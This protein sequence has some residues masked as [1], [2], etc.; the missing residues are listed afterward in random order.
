MNKEGCISVNFK[1]I[2]DNYEIVKNKINY[3]TAAVWIKPAYSQQSNKFLTEDSKDELRNWTLQLSD[4]LNFLG[5][6]IPIFIVVETRD[7]DMYGLWHQIAGDQDWHRGDFAVLPCNGEKEAD[8]VFE[9]VVKD[10]ISFEQYILQPISRSTISEYLL[11]E[12]KNLSNSS[13]IQQR[14]H[15]NL[16]E[17]V[18]ACLNS[19]GESES[20]FSSWKAEVEKIIDVKASG[21]KGDE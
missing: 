10:S 5:L 17:E 14:I 2:S 21:G 9:N 19:N 20:A 6:N 8:K 15:A 16:I 3:I 7:N 13:N 11:D 18:A 4:V 1:K 12:V